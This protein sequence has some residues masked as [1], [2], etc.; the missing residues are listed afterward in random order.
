MSY[1]E[2]IAKANEITG[3]NLV[4][5]LQNRGFDAEY[6]PAAEKALARILEIIPANSSVGIPGSVTIRQIGA[7]EKLKERGNIINQHWGGLSKSEMKA[8]R[9]AENSSDY[10][11]T[12]ANAITRDG[13]I[14]NIDGSGNRV[15]CMAWGDGEVIFVIGINKLSFDLTDGIKRARAAT[16]PNAIRQNELTACVKAGRCVD[17]RDEARMC[18]ATLILEMPLKGRKYHILIVGENLGY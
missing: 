2:T 12:S 8:A 5:A 4:K 7:I 14:I 13:E 18:R 17:C 6:I 11:L 9:F 15:A 16:I 10:F 3:N 1:A